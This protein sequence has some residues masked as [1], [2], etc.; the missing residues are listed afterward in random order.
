MLRTLETGATRKDAQL[1]AL[2]IHGRG[3]TP[4]EMAALGAAL[5]LDGVRYYAPEAPGGSWYPGRFMASFEANQPALDEARAGL[6]S[7][8]ERLVMDGF[9]EN[10][11]VLCG[12]S[13]GACLAADL[14]LRHPANY[15]AALI[16]TGGLI[17]PPNTVWRSKGRLDGLAV[18]ITGG[19][20]DEWVPSP[21]VRET[22]EVLIGLGAV[23][24]TVI[25]ADRPHLICDDEIARARALLQAKLTQA[26][27][28]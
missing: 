20:L 26:P 21:R 22:A 4:E 3:R 5:A 1:A 24:E 15:A 16:F 17:G 19:D 27:V 9:S 12:F 11:I 8:I 28:R 14:L 23:V 10:S 25:Y 18:L 7:I 2:M 6:E 13:Q